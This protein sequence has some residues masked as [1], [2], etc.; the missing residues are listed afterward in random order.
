MNSIEFY[1]WFKSCQS[2]SDICSWMLRKETSVTSTH[3]LLDLLLGRG[4][5]LLVVVH[6]HFLTRLTGILH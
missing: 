1:N 3:Y 2:T 4:D 6:L 5:L